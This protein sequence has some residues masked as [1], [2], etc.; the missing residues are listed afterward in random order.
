MKAVD[1]SSSLLEPAAPQAGESAHKGVS[2]GAKQFDALL[3]EAVDARAGS[4]REPGVDREATPAASAKSGVPG[5]GKLGRPALA[6][7]APA[8]ESALAETSGAE[9]PVEEAPAEPV[10]GSNKGAL[11]SRDRSNELPPAARSF[12]N[13]ISHAVSHAARAPEGDEQVT[14][15][16]ADAA[17]GQALEAAAHE[18]A[19]AGEPERATQLAEAEPSV[20]EVEPTLTS[21]QEASAALQAVLERVATVVLRIMAPAPS[22][23]GALPATGSEGAELGV[24]AGAARAH[25]ARDPA[26]ALTTPHAVAA[27]T[28]A[29]WSALSAHAELAGPDGVAVRGALLSPA[30]AATSEP[31]LRAAGSAHSAA[32]AAPLQGVPAS[33]PTAASAKV[34]TGSA[35]AAAQ[36][37]TSALDRGAPSG[38]DPHGAA[39]AAATAFVTTPAAAVVSTPQ[40]SST[41]ATSVA[42]AGVATPAPA[43]TAAIGTTTP[44][45][46]LAPSSAAGTSGFKVVGSTPLAGNTAAPAAS[47]SNATASPL[48]VA[49]KAARGETKPAAT[50]ETDAT[51]AA[52]S[53]AVPAAA[54]ELAQRSP[55]VATNVSSVGT[56]PTASTPAAQPVAGAVS[57]PLP[58]AVGE[59]VSAQNQPLAGAS[60]R[61]PGVTG[62]GQRTPGQAADETIAPL[63]G[64]T[65]GALVG[66]AMSAYAGRGHESADPQSSRGRFSDERESRP[67]AARATD[68]FG[69]VDPAALAAQHQPAPEA[70]SAPA[71]AAQPAI[72]LAPAQPVVDL[73][74]V[75]FA[76]GPPTAHNENASISLHHPE[77][78]PIRLEVHRSEGRIE[79]HAVI[80]SVHAEAV[81]RANESG[82]RQGVQQSGMTFSALR[83]RVRGDEPT[84][85]RTAQVRRRRANERET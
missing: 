48:P 3:A 83:V 11:L 14:P 68:V 10:Q 35:Q 36:P 6:G 55:A 30:N 13:R 12:H 63:R 52:F 22:G 26:Q 29:A 76:A 15:S 7:K 9:L 25:G 27:E 17:F 82:I 45:L 1:V 16:L 33:G 4:A 46:P 57:A 41:T 78:G 81:L 37:A 24:A 62:K 60:D 56:Q 34:A 67:E 19:K 20:E 51:P 59:L 5:A 61:G 23:P 54:P 32:A 49:T 43:Q 38:Q 64:F 8:D 75:E 71:F 28:S 39:R 77:L 40:T 31:A 74:T 70:P 72:P 42:G 85:S 84:T 66:Q 69:V 2:A 65:R 80:E 47:T 44:G 21:V 79:V 50:N 53:A 58:L 73:P 18:P